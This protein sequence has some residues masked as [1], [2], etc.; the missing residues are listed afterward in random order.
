[1]AEV[2]CCPARPFHERHLQKYRR[3]WLNAP[4]NELDDFLGHYLRS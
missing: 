4:F 2:F 1:V 3:I